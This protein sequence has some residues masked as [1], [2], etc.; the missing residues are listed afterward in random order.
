MT[1][2]RE[3][4]F[5]YQPNPEAREKLLIHHKRTLK[6]VPEEAFERMQQEPP[7]NRCSPPRPLPLS[8]A[9]TSAARNDNGPLGPQEAT[10]AIMVLSEFLGGFAFGMREGIAFA[11]DGF[12][13]RCGLPVRDGGRQRFGGIGGC[14]KLG[15]SAVAGWG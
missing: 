4:E 9:T 10:E 12:R 1:D 3:G 2:T 7:L 5:T 11:A 15:V 8:A 13:F 14:W 6:S